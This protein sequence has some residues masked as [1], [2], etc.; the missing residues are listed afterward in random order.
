M[1]ALLIDGGDTDGA[2]AFAPFAS[3]A[4]F[5]VM[6]VTLPSEVSAGAAHFERADEAQ[7]RSFARILARTLRRLHRALDEPDYN[8]VLRSAPLIGRG[9]QAA[10]NAPAYFRWHAIITPRLG[11]G[12]MAGFE[13]GSGIHSNGNWPEDD[14]ALLRA[15][16]PE[17]ASGDEGR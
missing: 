3:A 7:L 6:V 16:D 13:F 14:A 17:P 11:A 12:A 1:P 5:T 2:V 8:L 15:A 4:P 9:K 10:L